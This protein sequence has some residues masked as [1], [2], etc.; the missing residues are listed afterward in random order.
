MATISN[1]LTDAHQAFVDSLSEL[2]KV[3][4]EQLIKEF[5]NE[6]DVEEILSNPEYG[7]KLMEELQIKLEDYLVDAQDIGNELGKIKEEV[8]N[9]S[10]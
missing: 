2:I 4:K 6:F 1:E 7:K 10:S 5:V 3:A 8:F 9:A